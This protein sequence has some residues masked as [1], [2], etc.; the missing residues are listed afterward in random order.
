M[1]SLVHIQIVIYLFLAEF[2]GVMHSL[3][4]LWSKIKFKCEFVIGFR[5]GNEKPFGK[6]NL[7]NI[8]Q[9]RSQPKSS[10]H[11]FWS[12]KKRIKQ[13]HQN[14]KFVWIDKWIYAMAQY[15]LQKKT[16]R[17]TKS[18]RI[19]WKMFD[20]CPMDPMVLILAE[21]LC[22]I[23]ANKNDVAKRTQIKLPLQEISKQRWL[24]RWRS[25]AYDMILY[26]ILGPLKSLDTF[27]TVGAFD[28]VSVLFFLVFS[29]VCS[30]MCDC[31]CMWF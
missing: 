30:S 26:D 15:N 13:H 21:M 27:V 18:V 17:I 3:W 7:E 16:S 1:F 28:F 5:N 10:W 8:L 2:Q 24:N 12:R 29:F 11:E 22:E 4:W 19:Q 14:E 6:Q 25:I 20:E 31:V 9:N 23:H